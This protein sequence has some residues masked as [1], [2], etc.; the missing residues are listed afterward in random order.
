MQPLGLSTA[1]SGVHAGE[2]RISQEIKERIAVMQ[3]GVGGIMKAQSVTYALSDGKKIQKVIDVVQ[4]T[5]TAVRA[6]SFQHR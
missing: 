5:R 3:S 4:G 6:V 1:D 2:K